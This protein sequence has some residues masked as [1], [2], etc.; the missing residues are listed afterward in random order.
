M[1]K[2]LGILILAS[3]T[4]QACLAQ[5]SQDT[6]R[7][8]P[9]YASPAHADPYLPPEKRIAP[10]QPPASGAAL[11]EQALK[12]LKQQF[13]AADTSGNGAVTAVQ[14]RAAGLGYVAKN[15][16]QIDTRKRGKV[17]FEEVKDYLQ[18]RQKQQLRQ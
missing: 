5:N 2:L 3:G 15:F 10:T 8:V 4:T 16:E 18:Q 7:A 13:D 11:Q 6:A 14:A 1:K 17:S 12:K 9:P